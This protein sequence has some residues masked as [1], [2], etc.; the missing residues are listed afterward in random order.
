MKALGGGRYAA[1]IRE[2]WFIL[3]GPNGGYVAAN[4]LRALREEVA[5][6]E[7]A[8]RSLTIHYLSAP[9]AGPIEIAVTRERA[10]R[11]LTTVSARATQDGR[12]FA[13]ALAAF[14]KP[15]PG[16]E[17]V[18][19]TMPDVPPPGELTRLSGGV[20]PVPSFV[21]NLDIRW[22]IGERPFSGAA[23]A[24]VGGWIRLP[25]DRPVDELAIALFSDAYP[26]PVFSPLT[27][28]AFA[29]TVD[30]TVHFRRALP[31]PSMRD[32]DFVL[33]M[34]HS[35][36]THDG[37]FEEDGTLWSPSGEL[38]AHSRQLALLLSR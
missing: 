1:E 35:Q 28:P 25:G 20:A 34:F 10:G 7:R 17:R 4:V 21:E 5:D 36:S 11:S 2:R 19:H 3:R 6:P 30:L 27:Q 18:E 8:V 9:A 37:F 31:P 38:L 12:T 13:L 16:D 33:A 15:R 22:A 23:E 26:P 32:D 14:S 24:R 29:P